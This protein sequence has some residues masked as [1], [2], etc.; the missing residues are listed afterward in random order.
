MEDVALT[1]EIHINF[2]RKHI[3][4]LPEP[5][6]SLDTNRLSLLYFALTALDVLGAIDTLKSDVKEAL[7][8]YLYTMQVLPEAGTNDIARCGFRGGTYVGV[9]FAC[10][11]QAVDHSEW[12]WDEAHIAMTYVSLCCLVILGDD[13]SRVN[14][15]AVIGALRG[16]QQ[17]NGSFCPTVLGGESDI[18]FVFCAC[19]ISTL[20]GDWSGFDQERATAYIAASQSYDGGIGIGPH[21]EGHGGTTYCAIA[22][23]M[24]MNKLSAL[25]RPE[26]LIRWAILNQ[27]DGFK[28]RPEKPQDTCY[29]FWVGATMSM[30]GVYDLTNR[31]GNRKFNL[32]CQT[33][34]GGFGKQEACGPDLLHS[35][36]GLCGLSFMGLDN[37][38]PLEPRLGLTQRAAAHLGL[39]PLNSR[40]GK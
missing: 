30:M 3:Q 34:R 7:V 21:A 39:P 24:L 26:N 38:L 28:G 37:L 13:L 14:K 4:Y 5:Y 36:Y 22:S 2:F 16:L 23:L 29:S 11:E 32:S 31:E 8:H 27:G 20:L 17:P 35:C 1:R 18:R 19:A 9:P 6:K 33:M 25:P 12:V 40:Q 15:P 10:C